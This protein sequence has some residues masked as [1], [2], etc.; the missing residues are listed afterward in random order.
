MSQNQPR[1]W[2]SASRTQALE[3]CRQM[4]RNGWLDR[5]WTRCLDT[6]SPKPGNGEASRE[7]EDWKVPRVKTKSR[8]Q[9]WRPKFCDP[10]QTQEEL[11]CHHS[12]STASFKPMT[13]TQQLRWSQSCKCIWSL[14]TPS[15]PSFWV[16]LSVV[17]SHHFLEI[18]LRINKQQKDLY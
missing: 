1:Q 16:L 13:E 2:W 11:R 4:L 7:E 9:K 10:E 14:L 3:S 12:C 6:S 15:L 17:L 8:G 5:A 18:S